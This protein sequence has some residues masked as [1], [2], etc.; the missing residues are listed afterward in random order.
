MMMFL[1]MGDPDSL[2]LCYLETNQN[3]LPVSSD[4]S[5]AGD[6]TERGRVLACGVGREAE[7]DCADC[8]VAVWL[9]EA[10]VQRCSG[11]VFEDV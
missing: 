7:D 8:N 6:G 10:N 3:W 5:G 11:V 4:E 1:N 9:F 2:G